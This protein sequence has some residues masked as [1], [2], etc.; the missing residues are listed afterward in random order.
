MWP[1]MWEGWGQPLPL[2][3]LPSPPLT[4]VLYTS[5]KPWS[6]LTR[7][8]SRKGSDLLKRSWGEAQGLLGQAL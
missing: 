2:P 6:S 3:A 4:S 8:S 5:C 1:E 7:K